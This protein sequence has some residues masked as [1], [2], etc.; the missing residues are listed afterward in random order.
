MRQLE[1][2]SS[3]N[4]NPALFDKIESLPFIAQKTYVYIVRFIYWGVQN[5]IN[6]GENNKTQEGRYVLKSKTGKDVFQWNEET[7]DLLNA[8]GLISYIEGN[9][10]IQQPDNLDDMGKILKKYSKTHI[11]LF[12]CNVSVNPLA[13]FEE[14]YEG[15]SVGSTASPKRS[16]KILRPHNALST[17]SWYFCVPECFNDAL[18]IRLVEN[19][20]NTVP[21][22]I[23]T[24]GQNFAFKSGDVIHCKPQWGIWREYVQEMTYSLQVE[25]A[26]SATAPEKEPKESDYDK[27]TKRKIIKTN[28]GYVKF[29]IMVPNPQK[30]E[31]VYA[32]TRELTQA[33]FVKML[34]AGI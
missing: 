24:Q 15:I 29:K 17:D 16:T 22:A 6:K 10:R 21:Y 9:I 7:L 12:Q 28:P 4:E 18:D 14:L 33:E 32:E 5:A 11:S 27:N 1:I 19:K 23:W 13:L 31:V 3:E 26:M 20:Y 8:K 2:F 25:S 30:T 34:I